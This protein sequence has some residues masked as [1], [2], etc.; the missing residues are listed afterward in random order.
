MPTPLVSIIVRAR[1]EAVSLARLIP[2][3]AR[4]QADFGY[5][6]WLLDNDSHDGS[7]DLA[8]AAGWHVHHI[9]RDAFNYATALN[10]GAELA[11]GD[12]C[13][14]LS[15]HC[16]PQTD[17]WL[18]ELVRPIREDAT[19]VA[20]Y[21]RQWTNPQVAPFEAL[22]N[23][24]LFP[25]AGTPPTITA[26]SNANSAYRRAYA[27]QHPFNPVVR[28]LEDHLFLL[29]LPPESR[30]VYAPEALVHHEHEHFSWRY[31]IRRWLREGW[32]FFFIR[33]YRGYQSPFAAQRWIELE[34]WLFGYT[35]LAAVALK[36]RRWRLAL[37][38]LPFFYLRDLCWLIG[39][40]QAARQRAAIAAADALQSRPH[41]PITIPEQHS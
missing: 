24:S 10:T 15:A 29:E 41:R 27:L 35:R 40:M 19:I 22:G 23:D 8:R 39:R 5:E 3:L 26:F 16:F 30:V 37:L 31:N 33:D 18:A 9:P 36:R 2:L 17:R 1:N 25:P 21:G 28:I 32:S 20:S 12:I 13:V 7:A 14:S 4:Q 11:H 34:Q 38:T 6:V